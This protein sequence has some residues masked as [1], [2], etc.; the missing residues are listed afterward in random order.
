MAVTLK[1]FYNLIA[2]F[3]FFLNSVQIRIVIMVSME[4][5]SYLQNMSQPPGKAGS[6]KLLI[7][8]Y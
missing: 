7:R 8:T 5:K 2:L 1:V 4:Q 6:K 3:F